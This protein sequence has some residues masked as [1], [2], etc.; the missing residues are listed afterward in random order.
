M[1][2]SAGWENREREYFLL[3]VLSAEASNMETLI[4]VRE[5]GG[6]TELSIGSTLSESS[7]EFEGEASIDFSNSK[8]K[9]TRIYFLFRLHT[10]LQ[11]LRIYLLRSVST[12]K[13]LTRVD[14]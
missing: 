10:L 1:D 4:T 2:L 9:G 6:N 13:P 11:H 12:E 3:V 7:Q 8:G 14:T 5:V